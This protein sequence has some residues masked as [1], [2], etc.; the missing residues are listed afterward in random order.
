MLWSH[1][2]APEGGF[3]GK[4]PEVI[5]AAVAHWPF[6]RLLKPTAKI[7]SKGFSYLCTQDSS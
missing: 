4:I 6:P 5:S 2:S 7:S 1:L 3:P